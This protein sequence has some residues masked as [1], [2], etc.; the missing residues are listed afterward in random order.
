M[1][2]LINGI[3]RLGPGSLLSVVDLT[4]VEHRLLNVL[5]AAPPPVLNHAVVAMIFPILTSIR[6]SQKHDADR[7]AD[8]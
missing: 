8:P 5:A 1:L 2:S 3:N 6:R 7:L 4:Q